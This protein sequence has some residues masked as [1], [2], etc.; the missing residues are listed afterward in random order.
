MMIESSDSQLAAHGRVHGGGPGHRD[1]DGAH[2]RELGTDIQT[3]PSPLP[4]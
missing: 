1:P 2:F 3:V 4:A